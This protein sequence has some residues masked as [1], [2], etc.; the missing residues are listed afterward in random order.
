M[1]IYAV[2]NAT[3][4][5][6]KDAV[7]AVLEKMKLDTII[8]PIDFTGSI[9]AK[10]GTGP[11]DWPAGPGRKTKNVYDHGLG[12]SQW[13]M[14]GGKWKFVSVPIDKAAAPYMVDSTLQP[15]KPLPIRCR[16]RRTVRPTSGS[17]GQAARARAHAHLKAR[18]APKGAPRCRY[19]SSGRCGRVW[20]FFRNVRASHSPTT[21]STK[22]TTRPS[23]STQVRSPRTDDTPMPI[24]TPVISRMMPI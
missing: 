7:L 2:K 10:T 5:K 22:P 4:P 18:G 20:S 14:Q 8:G 1:A 15:A 13:L 17:A 9:I 23:I 24:T 21:T 12:G 19:S 16:Q 6:N 3:D 11:A